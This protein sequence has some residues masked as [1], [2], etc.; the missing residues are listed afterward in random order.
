MKEMMTMHY[1]II[2]SPKRKKTISLQI[3]GR[4]GITVCA[5]SFTPVEEI[6]RFVEA[7]QNWI[8]KSV[9]KQALISLEHKEKA[10]TTGESFYYLG[11]AYPL[12]VYNEPLENFGVAFLNNCFYLNC[13][14]NVSM[15]KF[16]FVSWYKKK[17][18]QHLS[19]RVD[20][21]SAILK[22]PTSG[23]RITSA[24]KRWGSCSEDNRLAFSFR[25]IM[26]PPEV[27]DYVVVHELMHVRQKN[28]SS[29]FWN[30]VVEVVPD[31][32]VHRQ[33]LREHAHHFNL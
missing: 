3:D 25:L 19:Q 26:A 33:W 20:F 14:E 6:N 18:K 4:S 8:V 30:L 13:P 12:E 16:Y 2:R 27:I 10:Y 31:Y 1:S 24:G 23:V 17:A 22:L 11:R 15:R 9:R 28:H 32:R 7:K 5:P 21:Y 29:K